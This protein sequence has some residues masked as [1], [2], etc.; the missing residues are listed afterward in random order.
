MSMRH[1]PALI[2]PYLLI[3]NVYHIN[4]FTFRNIEHSHSTCAVKFWQYGL[5]YGVNTFHCAHKSIFID[6][7][8][9][10]RAL[11]FILC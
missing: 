1:M 10:Y 9:I 6:E 8:L 7:P 2:S 5:Q 4:E 11:A 3:S